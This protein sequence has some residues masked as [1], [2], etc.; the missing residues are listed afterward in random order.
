MNM[1]FTIV[2]KAKLDNRYFHLDY[3]AFIYLSSNF[4]CKNGQR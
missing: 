1:L 2:Y 3:S 4:N